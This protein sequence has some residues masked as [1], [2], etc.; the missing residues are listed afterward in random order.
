MGRTLTIITALLCLGAVVTVLITPTPIDDVNAVLHSGLR[1]AIIL[2]T[3]LLPRTS[4]LLP[5][6]QRLASTGRMVAVDLLD[7]LS[8]RLC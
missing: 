5:S 4:Q 1:V 8:S 7:L 6:A 2:V 3:T